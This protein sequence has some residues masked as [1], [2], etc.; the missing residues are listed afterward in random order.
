MINA[1]FK[2]EGGDTIIQ[3]NITD[4]VKSLIQKYRSKIEIENDH[5]LYNGVV[6][7]QDLN[8]EEVICD[9]D[10]SRKEMI[11]TVVQVDVDSENNNK[12]ES[13]I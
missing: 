7:K 5:Y 4:K 2:Y 10:K 3:C 1:I 6:L 13:N 12:I 11:I 8:I 9:T